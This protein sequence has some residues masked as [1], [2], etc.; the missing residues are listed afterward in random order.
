[1]LPQTTEGFA[2]NNSSPTAESFALNKQW[3]LKQLKVSFENNASLNQLKNA[4][5]VA[6]SL[7]WNKASSNSLK[8]CLKQCF[9]K[10]LKVSL[11]TMLPKQLKLLPET[12]LSQA[13]KRFT[14]NNALQCLLER[15]T[16]L[17]RSLYSSYWTLR[18]RIQVLFSVALKFNRAK[19]M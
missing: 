14:W 5:T 19:V 2:W 16:V 12:M 4:S 1:M 8:F 18:L 9:P 15:L 11:E 10:Q 3:V 13:A 6:E 7:T 17:A